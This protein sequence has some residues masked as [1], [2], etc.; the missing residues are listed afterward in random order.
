M[1]RLMCRCNGYNIIV[2]LGSFIVVSTRRLGFSLLCSVVYLCA[3]LCFVTS[4]TRLPVIVYALLVVVSC[5][6][7]PAGLCAFAETLPNVTKRV[8]HGDCRWSRGVA[9]YWDGLATRD[10]ERFGASH[11]TSKN[12]ILAYLTITLLSAFLMPMLIAE[13]ILASS[14]KCSFVSHTIARCWKMEGGCDAKQT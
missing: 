3:C 11:L 1:G 13:S 6:R 10:L 9:A 7:K 12:K 14:Y 4:R 2:P 8:T 5:V